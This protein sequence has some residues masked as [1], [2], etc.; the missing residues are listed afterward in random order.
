ME[1]ST[2]GNNENKSDNESN[3]ETNNMKDL[4]ESKMKG[5]VEQFSKFLNPNIMKNKIGKDNKDSK[6]GNDNKEGKDNEDNQ[7]G[8]SK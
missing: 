2:K 8:E 4:K 3:K 7:G 5:L 6:E 1:D